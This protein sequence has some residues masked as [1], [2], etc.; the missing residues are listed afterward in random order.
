MDLLARLGAQRIIATVA[1]ASVT[2]VTMVALPSEPAQAATACSPGTTTTYVDKDANRISDGAGT[3]QDPHLIETAEQLI[4]LSK[5]SA[6]WGKHFRQVADI[7]L[8]SCKWTPIGSSPRFS[9]SYDG[10]F[11]TISNFLVD[12]PSSPTTSDRFGLFGAVS[13]ATVRDLVLQGTIN[14]PGATSEV[15]G[16]IGKVEGVTTIE[17]VKVNVDISANAST[18]GVGGIVGVVDDSRTRISYSVYQGS[19]AA[20]LSVGAIFYKSAATVSNSYARAT[21]TTTASPNQSGGLLG[22]AA[23]SGNQVVNSYAVTNAPYG[24]SGGVM[25]ETGSTGSFWDKEAAPTTV[26]VRSAPTPTLAFGQTADEMKV[27]DTY[28]AKSWAIVEGWEAFSPTATPAQIWGICSGVND[29]YPFLLWEYSSDP[30]PVSGSGFG[31]VSANS[32]SAHNSSPGIFLTVPGRPGDRVAGSAVTFGAYAVGRNAP[33]L[34]TLQ[35][36][37][38]EVGQ[39]I[40]AQGAVT[41]GGHL[42]RQVSIPVLTEGSYRVVLIGRG[43]RGELLTLTNVISVDR[44][45]RLVSITPEAMQPR[46]R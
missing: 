7:N 6:D 13:G 32:S 9:G 20:S 40:L 38:N 34:L 36:E 21:I 43:S 29:N 12:I 28:S 4:R 19:I 25:G 23:I 14:A 41:A 5:T 39:R 45:G 31:S 24:L 35:P 2:V 37:S 16:L 30:C 1:I 11:H 22:S 10:D 3:A 42:E 27:F 26:A 44:Q 8:A 46:I 33:Y 17:N 18:A 15:G